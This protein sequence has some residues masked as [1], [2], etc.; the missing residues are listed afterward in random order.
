MSVGPS[1]PCLSKSSKIAYHG[2]TY[3][4]MF[5][6]VN[7]SS[8]LFLIVISFAEHSR[9]AIIPTS[10]YMVMLERTVKSRYNAP[11]YNENRG[12][13]N[14]FSGLWTKYLVIYKLKYNKFSI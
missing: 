14:L 7:F 1:M 13:T 4:E 12:I 9:R 5:Y 3:Y 10:R 2:I 11:T 6:G 8:F